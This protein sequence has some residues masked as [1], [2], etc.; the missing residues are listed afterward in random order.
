MGKRPEPLGPP[1]MS[2]STTTDT[3]VGTTIDPVN[4]SGFSTGNTGLCP[5]SWAPAQFTAHITTLTRPIVQ[6]TDLITD[7]ATDMVPTGLLPRD[8]NPIFTPGGRPGIWSNGPLLKTE[9]TSVSA[10][11]VPTSAAEAE[12]RGNSP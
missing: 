11:P 9:L 2:T 6:Q 12:E 5:T 10:G 1:V 8:K 4:R 3:A 7:P